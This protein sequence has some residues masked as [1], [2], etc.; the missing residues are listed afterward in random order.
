MLPDGYD[1]RKSLL[2][3]QSTETERNDVEL[4]FRKRPVDF[5]R[6]VD[7][8][9]DEHGHDGSMGAFQYKFYEENLQNQYGNDYNV[10]SMP[11]KNILLVN[12]YSY[13]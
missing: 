11:T 7:I 5:E 6:R 4:V 3:G 10:I 9:F 12:S 2:H 13:T 8:R 1:R